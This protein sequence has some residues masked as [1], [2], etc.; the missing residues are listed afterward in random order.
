MTVTCNFD[1]D[2]NLN[3]ALVADYDAERIVLSMLHKHA[4]D[5]PVPVTYY[6]D[7]A[8]EEDD[9]PRPGLGQLHVSVAHR[10]APVA[11]KQLKECVDACATARSQAKFKVGDIVQ[12]NVSWASDSKVGVVTAVKFVTPNAPP[13]YDVWS[14]PE[15]LWCIMKEE[16]LSLAPLDDRGFVVG[17]NNKADSA[18]PPPSKFEVGDTVIAV[19]GDKQLEDGVVVEKS[20]D[21]VWIYLVT[22]KGG[23]WNFNEADLAAQPKAKFDVGTPVNARVVADTWDPGFIAGKIFAPLFNKWIYSVKIGGRIRHN[24]TENDLQWRDLQA[25]V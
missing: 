19:L 15:S 12:V 3:F 14:G 16:D 9:D 10:P 1:A 21:G 11:D 25:Q 7:E 2:L 17:A 23:T 5:A 24:F 22:F 4:S 13:R 6:V 18:A 8:D 20:F